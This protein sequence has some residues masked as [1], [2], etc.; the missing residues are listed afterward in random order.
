MNLL[1]NK[2][3][4]M[5]FNYLKKYI[6]NVRAYLGCN[7]VVELIMFNFRKLLHKDMR[8][9]PSEQINERVVTP[10]PCHDGQ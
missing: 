1:L 6:I 9:L 7:P 10:R 4:K 2:L 8:R 5:F 3:L